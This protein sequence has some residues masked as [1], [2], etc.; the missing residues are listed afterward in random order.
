MDKLFSSRLCSFFIAFLILFSVGTDLIDAKE[1]KKNDGDKEKK[2]N[3]EIYNGLKWRSIGPAMTSGRIADFAVN[4]ENH[5]EW[6][7]GVAS[8]HV[9]KTVNN[10]TTFK[11]VFD[12]E[13]SYSIGV[14]TMDPNNHNVIWVGT[15][16]NNHQRAL[17]YGNGVYKS[18]DGGKSW[19][20]VGLKDSRQIGGIVVHPEN[21]DKVFVAAE[22]SAWGPGG[23]RGLYM[24]N[25]GGES[26]K[27]VLEISENTGVN[28]VL[29]DP[30]DPDIMYATSEQRRRH[31]HTKIGGG[32]E[33]AV[34]R[35]LDGGTTWVK[36]TKGLPSVDIGGMGIDVSPVDHNIV[37]LIVEAAEGKGGFYKSTDRG[38]SWN[39][40]GDY[41]TSGQYYNEIYCDPVDV[42]RVYSMDTYS[43]VTNDG[44]KTWENISTTGRHVD[45]HAIWIDPDDHTH[46]MIGGDG[47]IYETYDEGKTFVFKSNLP[48]TQFYRVNV[49]NNYP[50]YNVYGGTQDNNTL[51]GPSRNRCSEGVSNEDW[52]AILGGDGFWVGI[53]PDDPGIVYAE[54]QYGNISRYDTKSKQ[55]L[56]VKPRPRK[57]EDTYKWN[58]NAPLVVSKHSPTR[59]YIMANKLFRSEDRGNSWD[60][61]SDDLT[62]GVDRNSWPAMGHFWSYDAVVKDVSTSLFGTGVSFSESPLDEDLLF[63]GTDD[64]VLSIS[65][66]GGKP[67]R[68]VKKFEGIP[69]YTYISDI[70]ADKF[71]KNIVYVSFDNRKRDD[72]KPYILKSTDKG[73][74]WTSITANLP[75]DGTVHTLEQDN[76]VPTLLFAGTEF[77]CFFTLDGGK[78]W[79][80]LKSGIPTIAV[81]DMVIQ[82]RENDLVLAT[83]GRG[84]YILDD[85]TPLRELARKQEIKESAAHIF[86]IPR[87]RMY[88]TTRA[89]YGQGSTF[90]TAKNP[91]VGAVI[92][93]YIKEIPKTM[94]AERK[95]MEKEL[96]KEKK[97]IP[98]PT[99][100]QLRAEQNEIAPY[101]VFTIYDESGMPVRRI[102][103]SAV[104]G[105]N[106]ITW[107]LR[108]FDPAPARG[109][110]TKFDPTSSGRAG[111]LAMP[112][113]YKVSM[114]LVARNEIKR[115]V[116]PVAFEAELLQLGTLPESDRKKVIEF[117][118][119]LS[120]LSR[121]FMGL[122]RMLSEELNKVQAIKQVTLQTPSVDFELMKKVEGIEQELK[123]MRYLIDG[124]ESKASWEELPPMDMPL[125][126]RLNLAAWTHWSNTQALTQTPIDQFEIL[127][128]EFPP[129]IKQMK[130][131]DAEIKDIEKE[132]DKA[133]AAW[134]PGR[135]M[136]L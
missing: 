65:E 1:K 42:D 109:T 63:A 111:I 53:S 50:F 3:T 70:M 76:E 11:P 84:F 73:K 120:E 25:D 113:T 75:E 12:N 86:K 54:S 123:D 20:N 102:T 16:E 30:L 44:G 55:N 90:Y 66:T 125:G 85:Y 82:G 94:K 58:W 34:Y 39:R 119:E 110:I 13:G 108:Y 104:K 43:R 117:Q 8:G 29:I 68:Q 21:S 126:R 49:D 19:K 116:E 136:E 91:D 51:M 62:S 9:W 56:T 128:E 69:E 37:Y 79:I 80:Q 18:E 93:Y 88:M 47:G 78:E 61:I 2:T 71:D 127:K 130:T 41:A 5:S 89:K 112:G 52:Q 17:G 122:D 33:S 131:I 97:P 31:V 92:T 121:V 59:I 35:S 135:L 81:R 100:D 103:K 132:L 10:G 23:D 99:R 36:S 32:P 45:D 134:T 4:P 77:G 27:K 124:P 26:W 28:N 38:A 83:F 107:D 15:G 95:E 48:V 14:V 118:E 60:V 106:R 24:T 72:F 22:G 74:S 87:A 96:F 105:I 46:F 101:L 133:G 67:W 57:G 114:D 7:V 129:L 98:Q 40:V 64:G 6:Y 115:L